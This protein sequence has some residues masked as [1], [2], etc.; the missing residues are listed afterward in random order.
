[1]PTTKRRKPPLPMAEIK[2]QRKAAF[3]TIR[4]LYAA[5]L[6]LWRSSSRGSCRRHRCCSGDVRACVERS[7]PLLSKAEQNRVYAQVV[8]G[9]PQRI[10]PQTHTEWSLRRF[11]SSN[12]VHT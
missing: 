11:P 1:M 9:G 5:A 3:A 8:R 2:A 10:P 4:A 6:P 7:W 12:F